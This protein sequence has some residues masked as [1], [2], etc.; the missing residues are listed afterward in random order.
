MDT[1]F[2]SNQNM[3]E[4]L[5]MKFWSVSKGYQQEQNLYF[6]QLSNRNHVNKLRKKEIIKEGVLKKFPPCPIIRRTI[7]LKIFVG[8]GQTIGNGQ[9]VDVKGI[10]VVVVETPSGTKYIS[11]VLFV[12]KKNQNL[13]TFVKICSKTFLSVLIVMA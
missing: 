12:P 9:K 13:L 1:G 5:E 11:D 8:L 10:E 6:H 3:I 7:M 2:Y 4:E